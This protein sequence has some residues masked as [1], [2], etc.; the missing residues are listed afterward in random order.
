MVAPVL[1]GLL[2]TLASNG[3]DLLASA[4]TAKGKEVVEEKLNVKLPEDG[5]L[6]PEQLSDLKQ[7]EIDNEHW[8]IEQATKNEELR[9][10]DVADARSM[11]KAA[12]QQT[13]LFSK[14]FIY[15]F[16]IFWSMCAA[17]YIGFITFGTI[18]KDNIRF[19]DTILGFIL[20]TVVSAIIQFF[21]GSS[22]SSQNKD[23]V[24]AEAMKHVTSR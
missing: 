21:Y 5:K 17:L 1:A 11:Q 20:G 7:K 3:L 19:A 14:R 13:D 8:L 10:K 16:A 2:T 12:L 6:T 24:V 9:L 4:I 22:K 15:Y 18:P 23:D